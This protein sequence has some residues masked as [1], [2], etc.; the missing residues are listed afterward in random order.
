MDLITCVENSTGRLTLNRPDSLN[1]LTHAMLLE[2]EEQLIKWADDPAITQVL[3]DAIGDKAFSAGGDIQHLYDHGKAGDFTFGEKFW[4]DE[5]R[6]NALIATYPK[7]YIALMQGF[8][9]GGGVGVSCHG[10]HRIVA[11]CTNI[12]LPECSI[13]LIPDV[14]SSLILATAPGHCGEY[15][16]ATGHRMKAE[17]AI[18]AGFADDY[19][20]RHRWDDLTTALIE[21]G[22]PDIIASYNPDATASYNMM[23][24]ADAEGETL[25]TL[26][27]SITSYFSAATVPSI[28]AKLAEAKNAFADKTLKILNRQSPLAVASSLQV[29][30]DT[31]KTPTIHH[32][33]E[34]EYRF[35]SRSTRDGDFL[36]GIRAA[37][38]DKTRDAKWRHQSHA[39]V[40]AEDIA[41]ILMPI[42]SD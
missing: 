39:D 14:G 36:E 20:P 41:A 23:P 32:A 26:E 11:D 19:I 3:V 1:A 10:S 21:T 33:L 13:G 22:Q 18:Y 12:A 5:Y 34:M 40:T 15:L 8:V 27:A 9:M 2:M 37:I 29:I 24:P 28:C 38:I 25:T 30:R 35:T 6:L 7:P 31:R 17:D 16:A 42:D 4:C